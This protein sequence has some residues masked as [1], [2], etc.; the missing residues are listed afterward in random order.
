MKPEDLL[1]QRAYAHLERTPNTV[2]MTQPLPGGRVEEYTR[3]RTFEEAKRIAAYLKSLSLPAGSRIAMLSKNC[4]SFIIVDLAIWMA[5][6]TSVAIFPTLDADSVGYILEHSE[7]EL[8][9]VG[10]LDTYDDM[11]PGIPEDLARV[12][13]P[14]APDSAR[15]HAHCTP[16][17]DLIAAH[18]PIDGDPVRGADDLAVIVYTSGSTGKPKG[19]MHSFKTMSVST[20][21]LQSV[22]SF[23]PEDRMLSYLPLAHVLERWLVECCSL[24]HGFTIYFANSLD[25]FIDDLNRAKPTLFVSVP[26]LWLK[27]QLGVQQKMP[28]SRLSMLLKVPVVNNI[29]RKKILGGLGLDHV[30]YAASGSAPIPAEVIQWYRDLGLELLEGYGMSENFA[31]SHASV[32]G[33][34][35]VGYVGEPYPEVEAKI[36]DDGEILVKSPGNMLG[37]YKEPELTAEAFTP[38]GFLRTGDRGEVDSQN[39]YKIT[40][41]VKELFKTS[42]GKYVAPAPIENIINNDPNVELSCVFGVGRPMACAVVVLS[43][44]LRA[45]I[46][47]APDADITRKLESLLAS[48]NA[49]VAHFEHLKFLAV[50]SEPWTIENKHL[51]PTMKIKRSRIEESYDPLLDAWYDSHSKV[52]WQS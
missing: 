6:H 36:S 52:L 20:K 25:T 33:R 37:Y 12:A 16:W 7:S 41:R 2:Y 39:R 47:K 42:K 8:I 19:V 29:I 5:G 22:L 32:P 13:M 11:A 38:D 26:R 50:A 23:G 45:K 46:G 14:L 28:Q 35:R 43:E 27:F 30:R 51:T 18:E 34:A 48:V 44:D 21:G 17:A 10:K 9:F 24:Y 4:A 31:Y 40:G 3:T 15:S 49:Q 1:L